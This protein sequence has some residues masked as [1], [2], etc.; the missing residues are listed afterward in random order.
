MIYNL[1]EDIFI[2]TKL[3]PSNQGELKAKES[4]HQSLQNL[5]TDYIDLFLIHWPGVSSRNVS[6]PSNAKLRSQSWAVMEEM[7]SKAYSSFGSPRS[8][9]KLVQDE[10]IQKMASKYNCSIT[11]FLLAWSIS[12]GISVLPRSTNVNHIADNYKSI[13]Y[14]I[15]EEDIDAVMS[16]KRRKYCWDPSIVS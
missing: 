2:I 12:Q 8:I 15:S 7:Y 14:K 9:D 6:D 16:S 5:H 10:Q 11:Q 3:K 1:R 13:Q 4:I